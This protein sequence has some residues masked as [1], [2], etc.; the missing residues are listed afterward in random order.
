MGLMEGVQQCLAVVYDPA[1]PA[2]SKR[3]AESSLARFSGSNEGV[4]WAVA[5]LGEPALSLELLF[6]AATVLEQ[7]AAY[8]WQ[9][10]SPDQRSAVRACLWRCVERALSQQAHPVVAK[11]AAAL[12]HL[13][14]V[15]WQACPEFWPEVQRCL[16]TQERVGLGLLL[17]N[18]ALDEFHSLSLTTSAGLTGKVRCPRAAGCQTPARHLLGSC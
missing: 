7:A 12:A 9:G 1:A 3:S 2:E 8:R 11:A 6:Y 10:L 13:T 4:A 17:L 14:C 15:D 18:T 5:A 16:G